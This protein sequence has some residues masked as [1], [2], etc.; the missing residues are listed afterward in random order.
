MTALRRVALAESISFVVLLLLGSVLSRVSSVNLLPVLGPLHGVLFLALVGLVLL[1]RTAM[2]WSWW[3]T[4]VMLTIG[5]P[6]AH[7]AV[8]ATPDVLPAQAV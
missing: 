4:A 8:H 6:G 3:F 7:F 5:S 2:G 1:R